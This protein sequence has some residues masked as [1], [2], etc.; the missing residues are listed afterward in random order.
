MHRFGIAERRAKLRA[1]SERHPNVGR[2]QCT[3]AAESIGRDP[4]DGVWLAIHLQRAADKIG[5]AAHSFPKSVARDDDRNVRVRFALLG[6]IK[7]ASKRFR[8]RHVKKVFRGQ[9]GKAAP[10]FVI[11]PDACDRELERGKIDKHISAVLA[12]LAVFVVGKLAVI[13]A[14]VL[15]GGEDVDDFVWSQWY[16]RTQ[17]HAVD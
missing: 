14:R 7:P 5:A 13:V 3:R 17:H 10:H 15:T 8:S 11:A 6:V 12:Q 4:D 9:E 2:D 1:H 16:W